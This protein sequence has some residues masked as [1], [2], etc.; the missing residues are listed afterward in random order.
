MLSNGKAQGGVLVPG[1]VHKVPGVDCII[2]SF[3]QTMLDTTL[4]PEEFSATVI[5]TIEP[6][7]YTGAMRDVDLMQAP[8]QDGMEEG[9][10]LR[11]AIDD[12]DSAASKVLM[13]KNNV[14]GPYFLSGSLVRDF[15]EKEGLDK[16]TGNPIPPWD[17]VALKVATVFPIEEQSMGTAKSRLGAMAEQTAA[18]PSRYNSATASENATS[19][20]AAA[21]S[22]TTLAL[23]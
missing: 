10:H 19:A 15:N 17:R 18:D 20:P 9:F 11:L 16:K 13:N 22:S 1:V 7:S 21:V 23:L 14:E 3:R 8:L 12:K 4:E 5:G 2:T 6:N